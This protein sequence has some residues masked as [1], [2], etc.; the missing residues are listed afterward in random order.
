MGDRLAVTAQAGPVIEAR[1]I[2]ETAND[3]I[4]RRAAL[5]A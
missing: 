2:E 1:V 4:W 3:D 5:A